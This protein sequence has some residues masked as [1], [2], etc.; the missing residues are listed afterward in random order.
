MDP[1]PLPNKGLALQQICTFDG[2]LTINIHFAHIINIM[3]KLMIDVHDEC[4]QLK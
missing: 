2:F 1:L 4:Q 3:K